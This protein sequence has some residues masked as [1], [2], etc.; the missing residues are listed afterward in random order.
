MKGNAFVRV[1]YTLE[2]R[3]VWV[4]NVSTI[5]MFTFIVYALLL[6]LIIEDRNS[7]VGIFASVS[8]S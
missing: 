7:T 3:K 4:Y 1:W 2:F 8:E 5:N 6:S